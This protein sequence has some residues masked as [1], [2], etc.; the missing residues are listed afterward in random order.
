[1]LPSDAARMYPSS[2]IWKT[3]HATHECSHTPIALYT[4]H[5]PP[6][7]P[8]T[9]RQDGLRFAHR[10]LGAEALTREG[11]SET[12][13]RLCYCDMKAITDE[14]KPSNVSNGVELLLVVGRQVG[15]IAPLQVPCEAVLSESINTSPR[16]VEDR[17]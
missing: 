16:S 14:N 10:G 13:D 5:H 4:V 6:R 17:S 2:S 1:M 9:Y 3:L 15:G 12:P 11:L 7:S 8:I